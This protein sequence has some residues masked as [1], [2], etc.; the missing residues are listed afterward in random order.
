MNMEERHGILSQESSS[1]KGH[2]YRLGYLPSVLAGE[3]DGAEC[4]VMD[5]PPADSLGQNCCPVAG[6]QRLPWELG[7]LRQHGPKQKLEALGYWS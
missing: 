4:G 3:G 1:T 2:A 7:N 5:R 6:G